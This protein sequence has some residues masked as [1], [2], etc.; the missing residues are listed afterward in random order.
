MTTPKHCLV[1]GAAGFIGSHLC[2]RLLALGHAVTGLD[3]L[4]TGRLVNLERA[5]TYKTYNTFNFL[6]QDAAAI[7]PS[8]L[9]G[10][11]WVFHLAGLADLVPSIQNPGKY[12]HAN[13]HSTYALLDACRHA[14]IQRFIYTASSTC[15]G[16]PHQ[17]PTPESYPCSPEHPYA[18]TKYLGEQLVLHWAKVY[19]LPALS[20]RLFNVYGPRSRTTGAYGAVFGVFL[21]QK[22]AGKPFTVVGDGSQTRDFTFVSDVVEAF[23]KAAESDMM[24]EI[25]NIC[26]G[27]PQSVLTLVKLLEGPITHIPKRPGEPDCTWGDIAKAKTLLGWQPQV[28]FPEG[29][30]QM[31]ANINMWREAPVWTPDA[32][33]EAT[34]E[35]FEHLG[36]N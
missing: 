7:T 13:V 21:A 26:S 17:Y 22:L 28:S 2:D 25:I 27:Q 33:Q 5:K 15:Y 8:T 29:V 34:K 19:K 9:E 16:I 1:T 11:D 31:L 35:W 12:Y 3:S 10:I 23:I 30:S 20:L 36:E 4:I 18:L 6:E 24:G 32:I 14:P